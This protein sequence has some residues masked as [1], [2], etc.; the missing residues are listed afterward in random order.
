MTHSVVIFVE[1]PGAVN[2]IAGLPPALSARGI[3]VTVVADGPAR[4][5]MQRLGLSFLPADG[6]DA[7]AI[8]DELEP[9]LVLVGTSENRRSLAHELVALCAERG[10]ISAAAVD[11][12][13]AASE[14]FRGTAE[15][16]LEHAPDWL[17][18]PDGWTAEMYIHLGYPPDHVITC[19]HPHYDHVRAKGPELAAAAPRLRDSLY[20]GAPPQARIVIFAAE[21]STGLDAAEYRRSGS[22]TLDGRG[23]SSGR[24]QVVIEEFLDAVAGIDP[25]PYC[26]LR[27]HPKNAADEF[28]AYLTDFQQVSQAE[29]ALEMI[30]A[31]DGVVGMTTMLLVEAVLLGK[32]TLSILPRAAERGWLS[33]TQFG[34]TPSAV[35]RA[36][37]RR[38]LARLVT[39]SPVADPA[40][41]QEVLPSGS[42]ERATAAVTQLL[43][44]AS[45]P[46]GS[47]NWPK[48]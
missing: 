10:I 38:E 30:A 46:S 48:I 4:A 7:A 22:Y 12:P 33:V 5:Y 3:S 24:T 39:G 25:R 9:G 29:P 2:F 8:I 28:A 23:E 32:P 43:G 44:Q 11:S 14:R 20:P 37:V 1:D 19:G 15:G 16:K 40:R 21:L 13:A 34:L 35:D 17:L 36:E 31:S 47:A 18:V 6:H 42:L 41:V 27:L 45:S 26:V